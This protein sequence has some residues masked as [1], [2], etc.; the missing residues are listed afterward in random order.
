MDVLLETAA[1]ESAPQ[2]ELAPPIQRDDLQ[3]QQRRSGS[4]LMRVRGAYR[5]PYARDRA[6]VMHSQSYRQLQGKHVL[7]GLD[8]GEVF[9]TR[10]TL[11]Q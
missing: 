3:W 9:R 2:P 5:N 8:D 4:E 7:G 11:A 10:A 6:R 1:V